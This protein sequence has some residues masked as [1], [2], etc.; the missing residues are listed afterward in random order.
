[1]RE[2]AKRTEVERAGEEAARRGYVWWLRGNGGRASRNGIGI[3][4]SMLDSVGLVPIYPPPL[5][6]GLAASRTARTDAARPFA[7]F[8]L[9]GSGTVIKTGPRGPSPARGGG[10]RSNFSLLSIL[11]RNL[12]KAATRSA[13]SFRRYRPLSPL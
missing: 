13:T 9:L 10:G 3:G 4:G 8:F 11:C 5:L 1:M 6:S 7:S 12:I 2:G